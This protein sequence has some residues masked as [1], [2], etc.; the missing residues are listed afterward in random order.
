MRRVNLQGLS[1]VGAE[2]VRVADCP[3]HIMPGRGLPSGTGSARPSITK[4]RLDPLPGL[5]LHFRSTI[6]SGPCR[7]CARAAARFL[8]TTTFMLGTEPS[9]PDRKMAALSPGTSAVLP[10][11]TDRS[12]RRRITEGGGNTRISRSASG[13]SVRSRHAFQLEQD[14]GAPQASDLT[15]ETLTSH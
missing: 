3:N 12:P 14:A 7:I 2:I 8:L 15:T 6:F 10:S 5:P 4:G 9:D 1:Y 11:A 13:D